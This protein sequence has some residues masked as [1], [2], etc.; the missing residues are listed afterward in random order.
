MIPQG[1]FIRHFELLMMLAGIAMESPWAVERKPVKEL[2]SL[3]QAGQLQVAEANG[4]GEF[5]TAVIEAELAWVQ[6]STNWVPLISTNGFLNVDGRA[7]T[8]GDEAKLEMGNPSEGIILPG[9]MLSKSP[10]ATLESLPN[11]TATAESEENEQTEFLPSLT[12]VSFVKRLEQFVAE[13]LK[14]TGWF[15]DM[16]NEVKLSVKSTEM[17]WGSKR[18]KIRMLTFVEGEERR[19]TFNK[20]AIWPLVKSEAAVYLFTWTL[21]LFSVL[22]NAV[23]WGLSDDIGVPSSF[24]MESIKSPPSVDPDENVKK[25]VNMMV[26]TPPTLELREQEDGATHIAETTGSKTDTKMDVLR[27][28]AVKTRL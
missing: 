2:A 17:I 23:S 14:I 21:S 13:N 6:P 28:F 7:E 16:I 19:A 3:E 12:I 24:E 15:I 22:E 9:K 4:R 26:T 1:A 20:T 8:D 10:G 11:R 27:E 18:N 5:A 25:L